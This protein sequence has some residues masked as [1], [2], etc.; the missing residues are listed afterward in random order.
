MRRHLDERHQGRRQRRHLSV[1]LAL[2][3]LAGCGDGGSA[4]PQRDVL[5]VSGRDDHG[6][7][8]QRTVLL[9]HEP[10]GGGHAHEIPA[11]TLVRVRAIRG[12][13]AHVETLE[14]PRADG[15]VND[16]YLRGVLHACAPGLPRSAQVELLAVHERRVRVRTVRGGTEHTVPRT[17]L[18]ELPC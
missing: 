14:G 3:A 11:G 15:W 8:A 5:L 9:A 17:A 2:V 18:S 7:L 4:A 10:D 6:L 1:A 12:E 13:W 16:Y